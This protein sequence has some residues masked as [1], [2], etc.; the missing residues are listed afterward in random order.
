MVSY[1]WL[2]SGLVAPC[3]V[4]GRHRSPDR[5]CT[6]CTADR[7][8]SRGMDSKLCI[9]LQPVS[10]RRAMDGCIMHPSVGLAQRTKL[11]IRLLV[12]KKSILDSLSRQLLRSPVQSLH[13]DISSSPSLSFFF[14]R[15]FIFTLTL[16]ELS[17]TQ[18]ASVRCIRWP[19]LKRWC[20]VS[21]A[22]GFSLAEKVRSCRSATLL[23]EQYIR[24]WFGLAQPRNDVT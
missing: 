17:K 22:L 24:M 18:P 11:L 9:F 7:T 6:V 16:G 8:R 19:P 20:A 21:A 10:M 12:G 13:C 23:N 14:F 1:R 3:L 4:I 15:F 2:F 5:P